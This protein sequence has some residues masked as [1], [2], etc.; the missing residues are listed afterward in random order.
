MTEVCE[1]EVIEIQNYVYDVMENPR[2]CQIAYFS[3]TFGT[4]VENDIQFGLVWAIYTSDEINLNIYEL[5]KRKNIILG[6]DLWDNPQVT[7][8]SRSTSQDTI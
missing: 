6:V 2:V 5:M 4:L 3:P 1:I 8:P 7:S